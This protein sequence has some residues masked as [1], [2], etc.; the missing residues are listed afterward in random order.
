MGAVELKGKTV[1]IT[2]AAKGIGRSFAESLATAG[3][4]V[5]M[6]DSDPLGKNAA[7]AIRNSGGKAEFIQADLADPAQVDGIV[8]YVVAR[9]GTVDML[10]NNA[11]RCPIKSLVE[12]DQ[13][14]FDLVMQVNFRSA[15]GC[16]KM[17]HGHDGEEEGHHT[18]HTFHSGC[19]GPGGGRGVPQRV[20]GLQ[21]G[22]GRFHSLYRGG[23]QT[24][25]D[26][27]HRGLGRSH[28]NPGWG[29]GLQIIGG[30]A[31]YAL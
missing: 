24:L 13:S 31:P 28:A 22:H 11:I 14:E 5:V 21:G 26:I 27:L 1:L 12:M 9:H 2:G 3:A 15:V 25:R 29:A 16:W 19:Q 10:V 30:A 20:R 17:H 6:V 8:P 23:G 4:N 7:E 18:E